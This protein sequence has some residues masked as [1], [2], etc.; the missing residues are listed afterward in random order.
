MISL[1]CVSQ[2]AHN[3]K[4]LPPNEFRGPYYQSLFCGSEIV[5][6]NIIVVDTSEV[7]LSSEKDF[8]LEIYPNPATQFIQIRSLQNEKLKDLDIY[9]LNG[10]R[11]SH[12][13]ENA[14]SADQTFR[15]DQSLFIP[16]IYVLRMNFG[17]TLVTKKLIVL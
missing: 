9:N 6:K 11:V 13:P 8:E 12:Y 4:Y 3:S 14:I 1:E 2:Y 7:I 17:T 5:T 10:V 16:G 15:L